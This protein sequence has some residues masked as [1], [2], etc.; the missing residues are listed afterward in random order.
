MRKTLL[1]LLVA[2]MAVSALMAQERPPEAEDAPLA[3][4]LAA[5]GD[6]CETLKAMALNFVCRENIKEK[7][8]EFAKDWIFVRSQERKRGIVPLAD[9]RTV[10]TVKASLVYDYQLI[11]KGGA[12]AERRDLLE[13][14]GRKK[15][16]KDV[17][18]KAGRMTGRYVVYGPVG[19]LSRSWQ[20]H[21]DYEILGEEPLEGKKAVVLRAAPR[22]FTE[23]NNGFGRIWLDASRADILQIEWEPES[24]LNYR[25]AVESP[26]GELKRK[27][28]WTVRYDIVKNG[29]RFPG[30]QSIREFLTTPAGK[31]HLKYE[32]EYVYD[33]YK[34]FTVETEVVVR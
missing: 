15:I 14:N 28:V 32:A 23:E 26:I 25:E 12:L 21:F 8:Y 29:I 19:F 1:G 10:K 20:P 30:S 17:E 18:L 16:Q 31:D 24:I 22:E 6:Y 11:K 9:L 3:R 27:I 5:A 4:I 13:E 33:G 7:T 34:F 2:E